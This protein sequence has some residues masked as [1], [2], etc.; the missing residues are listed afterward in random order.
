MLNVH[1]GKNISLACEKIDLLTFGTI[2]LLV[3]NYL[4]AIQKLY[5]LLYVF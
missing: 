2:K 3:L 4:N 1:M 5:K